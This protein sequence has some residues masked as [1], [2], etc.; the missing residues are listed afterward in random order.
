ML[1]QDLIV[2][3]FGYPAGRSEVQRTSVTADE[4]IDADSVVL[5]AQNVDRHATWVFADHF[6]A[7]RQ[8]AILGPVPD[9]AHADNTTRIHQV[10]SLHDARQ[11]MHEEVGRN[12]AGIRRVVAPLKV[13]VRVPSCLWRRT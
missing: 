4:V 9:A 3:V 12:P 8:I 2:L 10:A 13:V 5:R 7:V 1:C 6:K 11:A